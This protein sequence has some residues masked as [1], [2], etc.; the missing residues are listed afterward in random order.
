MRKK[1]IISSIVLVFILVMIFSINVN[2]TQAQIN[3]N[4]ETMMNEVTNVGKSN[5]KVTFSSNP[6]DYTKNNQGFTEIVN[7]G[8]TALPILRDRIGKSSANGLKE[9]L[10]AIAIEDI[11]KVNLKGNNYGWSNAK[12]FTNKWDNHL[13]S[14]PNAVNDI[15]KS[16]DNS[17]TK[18]NKLVQLGTPALPF[19]MDEIEQGNTEIIGA[20]E[21]L[22]QGNKVVKYE[23]SVISDHKAWIKDNKVKFEDLR[24]LVINAQKLK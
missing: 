3:K 8:S 10:L 21:P 15:A 20:L 2:K 11:A 16:N 7:T 23:K 12:N 1:L 13:K 6:Y 4:I 14:I 24:K 5:P 9:Y 17:I 18:V 19:I 22:L